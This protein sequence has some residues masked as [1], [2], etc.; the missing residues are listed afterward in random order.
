MRKNTISNN[1]KKLYITKPEI[2]KGFQ[3]CEE[4][5]EKYKYLNVPLIAKESVREEIEKNA[6]IYKELIADN[7]KDFGKYIIIDC[8]NEEE[9]LVAVSYL[10]ALY[11][12]PE[13]E[14][15]YFLEDEASS[16]EDDIWEEQFLSWYDIP[17][18]VP[19]INETELLFYRSMNS[20]MCDGMYGMI[21]SMNASSHKPYWVSNRTDEICVIRKQMKD[22]PDMGAH[23]L[24]HF[25]LLEDRD[26]VYI[27]RIFVEPKEQME[28]MEQIDEIEEDLCGSMMDHMIGNEKSSDEVE[29][30]WLM[31]ALLNFNGDY[32]KI[33]YDKKER[34]RHDKLVFNTLLSKYELKKD[35]D[36]SI[37]AVMKMIRE[38]NA[39]H[40]YE[41]LEK[42]FSYVVHHQKNVKV[43]KQSN[44]KE[45]GFGKVNNKKDNNNSDTKDDTL[46]GMEDVKKHINQIVDTL[47][48]NKYR[49]DVGL[50][51]ADYNNVFMF[52]GAPGTA[53]TTIAKMLGSRLRKEKLLK[54]NRFISITGAELKAKFVG[55]TAPRVHSIF[56]ENHIIF[57]DEA[58]SLTSGSNSGMDNFSGEALAQLAVELENHGKDRLIIFAGYGGKNVSKENNL[59]KAFLDANPGI[60]SRINDTIV[61]PSYNADEMVNIVKGIAENMSLEFDDNYD[62][63]IREYFKSR[64]GDVNFGNGREAR[65]FVENCQKLLA[66][67]VMN[68]PSAKRTKK[69]LVTILKE[70]IDNNI[71]DLK[72]IND[73]QNGKTVKRLGFV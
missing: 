63:E 73:N 24:E 34:D 47:L 44:F 2:E 14:E 72:N 51:A 9:G 8:K 20:E 64:T 56:E 60:K 22:M 48:Y 54:G 10:S 5:V 68:L 57:I 21:G 52:I 25:N 49:Q 65:S 36:I 27:I 16:S 12:H 30:S 4:T 6:R 39:E 3:E 46:V 28:Q 62:N 55:H 59:M 13:T 17:G 31:A 19:I 7:V 15:E 40:P 45:L 37:E 29:D 53:K 50:P 41:I 23:F 66:S 42:V 70:D 32:V 33:S 18:N 58:Y 11:N 1:K 67:R 35:K 43:L 38:N 69:N 71:K 61:F 26:R